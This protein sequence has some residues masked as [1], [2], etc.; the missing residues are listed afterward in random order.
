MRRM[1]DAAL[2]DALTGVF[3]R[4][5]LDERLDSELAYARR[6]VPSEL[7]LVMMDLDHFKRINDTHGH[8][9]GDAVL[10]GLAS[11]L[12]RAV[13]TEDLLARYGGEEFV[14]VT[15]E[16]K[17]NEAVSMAERLRQ[18]IASKPL[19]HEGKTFHVTVSAGVASL[20]CCGQNR[21]K[22]TLLGLADKRLYA[23]KEAGRNRVVGPTSSVVATPHPR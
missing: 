8:L 16:V 4:K 23:A 22:E 15:R 17:V 10:K 13:R 5:H 20:T 18:R 14:I 11:T 12:A 21:D 9:A 6:H 19:V 1:Y 2:R 3:N 7:S